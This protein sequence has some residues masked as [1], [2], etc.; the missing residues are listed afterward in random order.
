MLQARDVIRNAAAQR[1]QVFSPS[2]AGPAI[3]RSGCDDALS[4][5]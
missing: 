5:S 3:G 4:L 2:E 1:A